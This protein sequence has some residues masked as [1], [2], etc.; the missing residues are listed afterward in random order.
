MRRRYSSGE[1]LSSQD[2]LVTP[3]PLGASSELT[4]GSWGRRAFTSLSGGPHQPLFRH[5]R[6]YSVTGRRAS[7][8]R[9]RESSEE[10]TGGRKAQLIEKRRPRAAFFYEL[11]WSLASQLFVTGDLLPLACRA[12]PA[13]LP[14][15]RA[16]PFLGRMLLPGAFFL[17]R[18][19]GISSRSLVHHWHTLNSNRCA[20]VVTI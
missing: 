8:S 16:A 7:R 10:S 11:R 1:C 4:R 18:L 14:C 15:F 13:G 20:I 17:S 9:V 3:R 6:Y 2:R 5:L 19:A 12:A